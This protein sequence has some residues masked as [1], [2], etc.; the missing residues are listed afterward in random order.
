MTLLKA[1]TRLHSVKNLCL[2][3]GSLIISVNL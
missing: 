3:L 2:V 1:G